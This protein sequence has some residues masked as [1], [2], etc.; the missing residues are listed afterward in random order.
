M[1]AILSISNEVDEEIAQ[2]YVGFIT[3]VP[4][5]TP[6]VRR[7][8]QRSA[9]PAGAHRARHRAQNPHTQQFVV[10]QPRASVGTLM[11]CE[12]RDL[13]R[14]IVFRIMRREEDPFTSGTAMRWTD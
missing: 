12:P 13:S 2:A 11:N 7:H 5:G 8:G 14:R 3:S 4:H 1:V 9:H 6:F 10:R